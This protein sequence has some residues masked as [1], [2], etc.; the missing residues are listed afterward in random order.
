MGFADEDH[1]FGTGEV[2]EELGGDSVLTLAFAELEE[3]NLL[4]PG[5]LLQSGDEVLADGIHQGAGGE[6]VAAMETEKG[7]H[8]LLA[9]QLWDVN[10]QVHAV[11]SFDF[12]SDVL[13]QYLGD[14]SW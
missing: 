3:G 4:V 6:L 11:D 10:I 8:A 14:A 1:A 7:G 9:L 5:K 13:G 2:A 12:E